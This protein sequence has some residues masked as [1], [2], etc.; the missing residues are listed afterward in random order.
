[1]GCGCGSTKK[2][3]V[4]VTTTNTNKNSPVGVQNN[5]NG[6]KKLTTEEKMKLIKRITGR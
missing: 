4:N 3:K 2:N 1:M 5:Q 6:D